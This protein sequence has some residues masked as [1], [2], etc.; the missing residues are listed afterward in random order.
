MQKIDT[1]KIIALRKHYQLKQEEVAKALNIGRVT[2]IAREKHGSFTEDEL[3]NLSKLLNV[4]RSELFAEGPSHIDNE[5]SKL[6]LHRLE[7]LNKKES[8][9]SAYWRMHTHPSEIFESAQDLDDEHFTEKFDMLKTELSAD[10][11]K[12]DEKQAKPLNESEANYQSK[13]ISLLESQVQEKEEIV[14]E[15]REMLKRLEAQTRL[16][17]EEMNNQKT[18]FLDFYKKIQFFQGENKNFPI[19]AVKPLRTRFNQNFRQSS[20]PGR[21]QVTIRGEILLPDYGNIE[22]KLAPLE[23]TLYLFFLKHPEGIKLHVLANHKEELKTIYSQIPTRGLLT[24]IYNRIDSLVEVTSNLASE[25]IAKIKRAFER[26]VG[27]DLAKPYYIQGERG[28][29]QRIPLNRNLV[30]SSFIST[31]LE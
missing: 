15:L 12:T 22:I 29:K 6:I 26:S 19:E 11:K 4:Q 20:P 31:E 13:Y 24:E 16:M 14:K 30:E 23:K 5:L 10:L 18:Q 8:S 3:E 21:L 2:Y 9:P 27:E 25:K 28:D 17:F 7:F 1:Y